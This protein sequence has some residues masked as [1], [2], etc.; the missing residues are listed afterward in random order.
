MLYHIE[1]A[2]KAKEDGE[3]RFTMFVDG[4]YPVL[5]GNRALYDKIEAEWASYTEKGVHTD[6]SNTFKGVAT[7]VIGEAVKFDDCKFN[8]L[9]KFENAINKI[10]D[11]YYFNIHSPA[12]KVKELRGEIIPLNEEGE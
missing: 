8:G 6:G 7:K 11:S 4:F 5:S 3:I 9:S 2:E 10:A 12:M 1:L